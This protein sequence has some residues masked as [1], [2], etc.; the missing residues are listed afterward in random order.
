MS[1]LVATPAYRHRPDFVWRKV[2]ALHLRGLPHDP[3]CYAIYVDGDLA[4]IGQTVNLRLRFRRYHFHRDASN[5]IVT[6]WGT[7]K[8]V[9]F[10]I[11]FSR[12]YGD[13]AMRELR[14]I[15]RLQPR[16]NTIKYV[17]RES[18]HA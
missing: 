8:D 14:L 17:G 15:R 7:F 13:W 12:K 4:Y 5:D 11:C 1:P 18:V 6:P 2:F 3:G 16:F 10:K 9:K